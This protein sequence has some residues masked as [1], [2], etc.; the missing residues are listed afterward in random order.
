M[1]LRPLLM[2]LLYLVVIPG[3]R[4]NA[5]A[6]DQPEIRLGM[7]T[8]LSGPAAEL[9]LEM[10]RGVL[11]ALEQINRT[12]GFQGRQLRLITYDDGYEPARTAPNMHRLL[13][14]DHV[15]AVIGNVGTPTAIASLPQIR[16][17]QTLFFAPFS[18]AGG[19]R[20][21]PP[22]RYVI[23]VRASYAE[24]ITLMVD[25]LVEGGGLRPEEIAFF[26]QRDGYG[27]AGY[28]GGFAALKRHGLQNE[29]QVLHVRYR[30]NTLAVENALADLL[31]ADPPPRALIMVGAYAPCAK[32]IR[33]ARQSGFDALLLNVSF[34]GS[35]ALVRE[36]GSAGEGVVI[37]QVVPHP[38]ESQLPLVRDYRA[39]LKVH[40]QQPPS[41][42]SLE[43]YFAL[44]TLLAGLEKA[45]E[46]LNRET[47]IDGLEHLGRFDLGLGTAL[48]L[49][50]EDHQASHH[51]WPTWVK[52]GRV[53]SA[54][55]AEIVRGL[56]QR[57]VP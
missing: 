24:E 22:E 12:G 36:L 28:V 32:F 55:W 30:R 6:A 27:D 35:S 20:R 41:F 7:S 39:A 50:S 19:L 15:L 31:L 4:S 37:T 21:I 2:L 17:Q 8:V 10:Q 25:A 44:R 45:P 11:A 52:N 47:L 53:V 26:T 56:S 34:V 48:Q 1:I 18:G 57:S 9:G 29:T 40:D 43:G 5:T 46:P 23:N 3:G 16:A 33:L 42:V 13:E 38:L 14:E 54:S 49:T 51:V